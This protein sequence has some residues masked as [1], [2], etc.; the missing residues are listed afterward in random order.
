MI[1]G[2]EKIAI[3]AAEMMDH[4]DQEYGEGVTIRD[5]VICVEIGIPHDHPE[6]PEDAE[7]GVT[8]V[9]AE[10]SN[11]RYVVNLGIVSAAVDA[12]KS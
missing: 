6:C 1:E 7:F 8:T 9:Y 4:L 2:S 5:V 10:P 3:T 11:E 12:I